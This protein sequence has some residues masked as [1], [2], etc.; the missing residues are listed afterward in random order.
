[1]HVGVAAAHFSAFMRAL[2]IQRI[3]V[4]LSMPGT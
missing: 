4:H 1:M 3:D 2:H